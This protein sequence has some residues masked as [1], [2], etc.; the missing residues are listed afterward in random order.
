MRRWLI[1]APLAGFALLFAV[2]AA[3]LFRPADRTVRSGLVGK[4]VP[5][6]RLDPIVPGKPGLSA[7]SLRTGEPRL[8]N[9]FA[10]W[11]VP[12]IA[13]A[14]QLMALKRQ[15]VRIDGVAVRD[16]APALR[17]FLRRNGDPFDRIGD[18]KASS[19]QLALGSAGVPESFVVDGRGVI[20]HQHVGYI[21]PGD[22]PELLA[23]IERAR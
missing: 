18:D 21:S 3:G 19:V 11:C 20:R 10:S 22:V 2:V 17:R 1:W 5:A 14:P 15:G 6:F 7:A 16:T 9:I 13:E 8:V 4:P 12:C 23:E